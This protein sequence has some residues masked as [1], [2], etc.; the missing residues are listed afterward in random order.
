MVLV[1]VYH[2]F[3]VNMEIK[4]V[5]GNLASCCSD[6]KSFELHD[7]CV[8]DN[9]TNMNE[10]NKKRLRY[11]FL[12]IHNLSKFSIGQCIRCCFLI[13]F[14]VSSISSYSTCPILHSLENF[15]FIDFS[16]IIMECS[17]QKC[18]LSYCILPDTTKIIFDICKKH[19]LCRS[20]IAS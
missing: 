10:I 2:V 6:N 9:A 5:N 18:F 11:F 1:A 20:S 14:L 4:C 15:S 17:F 13:G 8:I 16:F 3:S 19:V 12:N 7:I